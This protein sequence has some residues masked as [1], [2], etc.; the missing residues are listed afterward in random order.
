MGSW[1]ELKGFPLKQILAY[2]LWLIRLPLE[3]ALKVTKRLRVSSIIKKTVKDANLLWTNL[4]SFAGE[5][6]SYCTKQLGKVSIEAIFAVYCACDNDELKNILETYITKW[7]HVTQRT[8][9]HDL[10]ALRLPPGPIYKEILTHLRNA[11]LDGEVK[12]IE[13]ESAFLDDLLNKMPR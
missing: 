2:A 10:E 5:K 9:G 8:T 7:R 1:T 6:P 11:W 4:P 3:R 12:T 13:D